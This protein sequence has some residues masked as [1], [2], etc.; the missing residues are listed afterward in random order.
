MNTKYDDELTKNDRR[1]G[2]DVKVGS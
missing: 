2:T 1:P